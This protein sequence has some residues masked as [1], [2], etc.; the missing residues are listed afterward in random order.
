MLGGVPIGNHH[1][2]NGLSIQEFTRV[3]VIIS[4]GFK[5]LKRE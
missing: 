4:L 2:S 5:E 3:R 1:E